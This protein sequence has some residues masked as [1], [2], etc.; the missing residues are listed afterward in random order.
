[1]KKVA[2]LVVLT[3][4]V[5]CTDREAEAVPK[6]P[7]PATAA[8]QAPASAAAPAAAKRVPIRLEL[9]AEDQQRA[10]DLADL[11]KGTEFSGGPG[12]V[13]DPA[14]FPLFVWLAGTNPNDNVVAASL[15]AFARAVK[16]TVDD[17]Y[18]LL[19][20][21]YLAAKPAPL[22]GGALAATRPL[23][24]ADPPD[25][26][27][28]AAVIKIA[29]DHELPQ[30]RVLAVRQLNSVK[31]F[32]IPTPQPG[33][34]KER[35]V[36]ALLD[37]AEDP[38]DYVAAGALMRLAGA[39]YPDMP[40]RDALFAVAQKRAT[41]TDA[42]VR[43]RALQ[44]AARLAKS[45]EEKAAAGALA[46]ERLTDADPFVR[47]MAAEA[48]GEVG[49][50]AALPKLIALVDDTQENVHR[51]TG[52]TSLTGE[53][54]DIAHDGSPGRRVDD[55]ALLALQKLTKDQGAKA[56]RPKPVRANDLAADLP[57][58]AAEA[59]AWFARHGKALSAK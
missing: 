59:K 5:G 34:T 18:R 9:S 51:R 25:E 26:E 49:R 29:R 33:N 2:S 8:Q 11:V 40:K 44:L 52:V 28:L 22:V 10:S 57:K 23:L 58:A 35:V 45:P 56:F 3:L 1:M 16:P 12:I 31:A 30:A 41:H 43:G 46:E 20:K 13:R 21:T 53:P 48:V 7:T 54:L 37:A 27:T 15:Q 24:A 32:Q 38:V 39:A 36:E 50:L 6:A 19:V 4:G 47:S 17:D 42:A 55:A 14:N